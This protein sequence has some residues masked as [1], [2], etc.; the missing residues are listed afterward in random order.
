MVESA[1]RSGRGSPGIEVGIAVQQGDLR[2]GDAPRRLVGQR[3]THAEVFLRIACI[4]SREGLVA[5]DR[6]IHGENR[7]GLGDGDARSGFVRTLQGDVWILCRYA[8]R[9][10]QGKSQKSEFHGPGLYIAVRQM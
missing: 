8:A 7:A 10:Q 3:S 1:R 6:D 2:P 4:G 5:L 9:K